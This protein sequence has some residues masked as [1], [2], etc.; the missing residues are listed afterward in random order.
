MKRTNFAACH[1]CSRQSYIESSRVNCSICTENL[2]AS[3][4]TVDSDN[5]SIQNPL[6]FLLKPIE[7][8]LFLVGLPIGLIFGVEISNKSKFRLFGAV[9]ITVI[10]LGRLG[11]G[12]QLAGGAVLVALALA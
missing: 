10:L 1:A 6:V 5:S 9:V 4:A 3:Q 2:L 11:I 8:F 7:L 12:L